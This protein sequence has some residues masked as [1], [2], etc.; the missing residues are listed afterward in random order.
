MQR[1]LV[2]GISLAILTMATTIS[3]HAGT[4][5]DGFRDGY[6]AAFKASNGGR[7]PATPPCPPTPPRRT[8]EPADPYQ[9]GYM[10]GIMKG[11]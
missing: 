9:R 5:C 4:Y 2:F 3:A 10:H 1:S 7:T 6:I 11:N 8:G